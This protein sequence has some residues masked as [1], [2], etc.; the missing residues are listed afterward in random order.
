MTKDD[1]I[2][3]LANTEYCCAVQAHD[4]AVP[5]NVTGSSATACVHTFAGTPGS[6]NL[7]SAGCS[8]MDVDVATDGNPAHTEYAIRCV[9]G[10]DPDWAN[11]Y[12]SSGGGPSPS[13]VW[14]TRAGWAAV[15]ATGL[16]SGVAY[17][18]QV[19]ARNSGG[20][21]T[22]PGLTASYSTGACG[23]MDGDGD[24]D[25]YDV[26]MWQRCFDPSQLPSGCR[27]GDFDDDGSVDLGDLAGF[28]GA[29]TGP[30]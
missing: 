1:P 8:S 24:I 9:G 25:L 21:L 11:K 29:L 2:T 26:A 19:T 7:G 5:P 14:R 15:R 27:P 18:F 16:Q 22:A 6:P 17:T 13:A 30:R 23:Y 20:V 28:L 4:S 12:V 10:A 3:L